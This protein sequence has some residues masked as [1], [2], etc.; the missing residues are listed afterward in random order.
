MLLNIESEIPNRDG[1]RKRERA[2]MDYDCCHVVKWY[3][4]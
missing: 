4:Y 1:V 3:F 2:M